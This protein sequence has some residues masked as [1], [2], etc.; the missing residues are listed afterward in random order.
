MKEYT[1]IQVAGMF[2][3]F[4]LGYC[5]N[6]LNYVDDETKGGIIFITLVCFVVGFALLS[7]DE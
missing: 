2:L 6:A 1:G 5:A 4:G 7:A 3:L